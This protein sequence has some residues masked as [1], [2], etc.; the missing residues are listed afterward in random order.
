MIFDTIA[1]MADYNND[2]KFDANATQA[3]C[4]TVMTTKN[5]AGLLTLGSG[6]ITVDSQT[7]KTLSDSDK[8]AIF[9]HAM[10]NKTPRALIESDMSDYA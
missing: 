3:Q 8:F 10:L 9:T 2:K 6:T 1:A 7:A 4:K 5:S